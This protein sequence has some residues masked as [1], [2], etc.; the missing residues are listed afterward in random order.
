MK[1]VEQLKPLDFCLASMDRLLQKSGHVF[2]PH[3]VCHAGMAI[4]G[5]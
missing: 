1:N 3:D 2:S 4:R 5:Y